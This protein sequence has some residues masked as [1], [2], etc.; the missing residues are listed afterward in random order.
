MPFPFY[1]DKDLLISFFDDRVIKNS[2]SIN[3]TYQFNFQEFIDNHRINLTNR[4]KLIDPRYKTISLLNKVLE[5]LM[6]RKEIFEYEYSNKTA[7]F[8]DSDEKRI[9]LKHLNKTSKSIRG[10]SGDYFWFYGISSN[11]AL[12]PFPHYKI[13]HHVIFKDQDG[14]T[15]DKDLQH[16][17][18][19][20]TCNNWF[21]KDW[22]D[23]L[24][25]W[26]TKLSCENERI[27]AHV[28]LDKV[29]SINSTPHEILSPVGYQAVSYTHLTLPTI[30]SV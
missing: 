28:D 23:R 19:R 24:L 13:S 20:S 10:K 3:K 21:N 16:S 7:Y 27:S 9:S 26:F 6:N 11:V 1:Q 2:I 4:T 25:A 14:Q 15:V 17:L 30:Y 5:V 12:N 18:R 29:V 8:F 22:L